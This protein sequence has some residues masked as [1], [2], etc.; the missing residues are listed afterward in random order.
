MM[1]NIII[2]F[3]GAND[4]VNEKEVILR[5]NRIKFIVKIYDNKK[6]VHIHK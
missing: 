4:E 3:I 2:D 5:V 6:R 1:G